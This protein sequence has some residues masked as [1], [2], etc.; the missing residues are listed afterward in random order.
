MLTAEQMLR[1]EGM[2]IGSGRV[3]ALDLMDRAGRLAAEAIDRSLGTFGDGRRQAA[4][5]CG[6]G[7]NGGDGYA[8][9][10][11]LRQRGWNPKVW[12]LGDPARRSTAARRMRERWLQNGSCRPL[13]DLRADDIT[14]MTVTVDAIFGI[15]LSRR[16]TGAAARALNA[17]M[18]RG[19]LAAVDILTGIDSDG[20]RF[21]AEGIADPRPAGI[22][23][24]FETPKPGHFIG[25]GGR[26]TG[27][28]IVAPLGLHEELSQLGDPDDLV[29]IWTRSEISRGILAKR[30]DQH[31]YSHGHVLSVAGPAG[32]GGAARLAARAALRAGAGL[33]TVAA[34]REAIAEH[35]AQLNAVMLAEG[36]GPRQLRRILKDKRI[37]A[38][39]IG[40]GLG[41]GGG[42]RAQVLAVLESRRNT[43]LDADALTAFADHPQALFEKLP[44]G[45][46]L[47]PHG[48]EFARL[49]PAEAEDIRPGRGGNLIEAVRSAARRANA[50]VVLKGAAT[51][52][53]NP[54]GKAWI[55][56]ATGGDAV[57]WLA[58][59][60]SGDVLTGLIAGLM[61]RGAGAETA[62]GS[63]ACLHARAAGL[64]GPGLI[65]EDLPELIPSALRE[66]LADRGKAGA[67]RQFRDF[68]ART[69]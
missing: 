4:V 46:V 62:A 21:I 29:R 19:R 42:A 55:S 49:F 28:L 9:A 1:L 39:C 45:T 37:N 25:A 8:I 15:G 63:G 27:R 69:C 41:A 34:P 50:V 18:R 47:T 44:G 56:A 16:V 10:G 30:A 14:D 57:P 68:S 22:T 31:K 23:V 64:F 58:T 20:G 24:T 11:Y 36:G 5:L 17:A 12:T 65:A 66:M 40:P 52:I 51:V 43:V 48:G 13:A 53:A 33:V 38:V 6:P 60:G 3:T 26:L 61:A 35:A 59:A 54:R 7:N 32:K 67:E 2:A